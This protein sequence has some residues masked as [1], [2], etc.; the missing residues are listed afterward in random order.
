MFGEMVPGLPETSMFKLKK[1]GTLLERWKRD[2]FRTGEAYELGPSG[3]SFI[4]GV[5]AER[6]AEMGELTAM[7]VGK[8]DYLEKIEGMTKKQPLFKPITPGVKGLTPGKAIAGLQVGAGLYGLADP[9]GTTAQKVGAG[10]STA[11]G[12]NTLLAYSSA[13]LW[14]PTGWGALA[15]GVGATL[16]QG[17]VFG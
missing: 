7:G 5:K 4:A 17:G 11:L 8:K 10:V 2:F 6:P 15:A 13:N 1:T 9:K 3:E 12:I 16:A 14:N